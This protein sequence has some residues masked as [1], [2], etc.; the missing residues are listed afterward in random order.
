MSGVEEQDLYGMDIHFPR[1]L[2]CWTNM[3]RGPQYLAHGD[4]G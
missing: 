2:E 4:Q 3:H 1:I